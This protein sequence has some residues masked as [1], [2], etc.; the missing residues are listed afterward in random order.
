MHSLPV[1][2][3]KHRHHEA[4]HLNKAGSVVLVGVAMLLARG[5]H[6]EHPG[7]NDPLNGPFTE[8]LHDRVWPIFVHPIAKAVHKSYMPFHV[9]LAGMRP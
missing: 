3:T 2:S 7:L 8:P 4:R 6:R 9:T 5:L 1:R